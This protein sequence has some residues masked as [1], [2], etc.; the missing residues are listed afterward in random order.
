MFDT[1]PV[2]VPCMTVRNTDGG[3]S[4]GSWSVQ[5]IDVTSYAATLFRW[6]IKLLQLHLAKTSIIVKSPVHDK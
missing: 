5:F 1:L 4:L 2:N 3:L 6:K